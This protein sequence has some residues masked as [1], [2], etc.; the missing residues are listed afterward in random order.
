MS[1]SDDAVAR[2][3]VSVADGDLIDW[4]RADADLAQNERR[5]LR[6][7]RLV[8]SIASLHRSAPAEDPPGLDTPAL[9]PAGPRWGPLVVLERVGEGASS[10]VYRAWDSGLHRDVALKLIREDGLGASDAD[11]RTLDEG[12]RLARLRH[13]NVVHVY[14]AEKHDGRIGLW[15]ELVVGESLEEIVKARGPFGAREAAGIG[16]DLCAALAAVHEKHLL[17]RDIKA[18]NVV[19]EDGGRI[20]LMDFGTGE[21]LR[22]NLGT[23]RLVGTPLYLAP[24]IFR[25]EAA[26][27]QSDL[28]SLGVLLF[29]LVTGEFPVVAGN[30][31]QLAQAHLDRRG[32]RLRDLRPDLPESFVHAVERALEGDRERRFRTAGEMEA[33]L[34]ESL[35]P[36]E[37]P[38]P[39]PA[40]ARSRQARHVPFAAIAAA[41][42]LAIAALG[43]WARPRQ[44]IP[45][46]GAKRIAVLPLVDG[47]GSPASA[48]LASTLTEELIAGLGQ[49][50]ALQVS[51]LNSVL[52]FR[53]STQSGADISN[54]LGVEALVQGMVVSDDT[55]GDG[56]MRAQIR[57][58]AAGQP[59][60]LLERPFTRARGDI[61][62]LRTEIARA[63]ADAVNVRLT[64]DEATRFRRAHQ[65]TPAAEEAY[66]RGRI[67]LTAYGPEPARQA[68][69]AFQR[70]ISIDRN[71]AAAYAG[72]ARAYINLALH[73]G[74][75]N[76]DARGSATQAVRTALDLDDGLADGH[77]ILAEIYFRYDW[78][79]AGAEREYRTSLDLN[80]SYTYARAY[81]A[82]FLAAIRRFDEAYA[83]AT[84]AR[85]Q[86]PQSSDARILPAMVQY[87]RG[88]FDAAEREAHADSQ[89]LAR[90]RESQGR[91]E[92]ALAIT[93]QVTE[94][95]AD[96]SS[97][98]LRVSLIRRK[99]LSGR[100]E[101][102]A[103]D[104]RALERDAAHKVVRF[105]ARDQG[106][107]HLAFG[108]VDQALSA[109]EN[110]VDERDPALVWV[111]VDPRLDG[112]RSH[113][114]FRAILQRMKMP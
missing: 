28:Y 85:T 13:P 112:I 79:W 35:R 12:R 90:I 39:V 111:G 65:T 58:L 95:L 100:S 10:D 41:T 106:F 6:H 42:L 45:M 23:N 36:S 76:P 77:A 14:G 43:Y 101:A 70:A 56:T 33:A 48:A 108:N 26:S 105:T 27:V 16:Q 64:P 3:A 17:H 46:P 9:E 98:P 102:A 92:E 63:V 20:V 51:P 84:T 91:F 40:R 29:Y 94:R 22:R 60:V 32:R 93:E 80:P 86:D 67:Q 87:Y 88:D 78:D 4:N 53:G 1:R 57:V 15:M 66:I 34:R 49:I 89:L 47:S 8:E 7:L 97:V 61:E 62:R 37:T 55:G 113:P 103:A 74:M 104:L 96:S 71:Y 44:P 59:G 24:E 75:S 25:G 114:R 30:M 110:A 18:Q 72:L 73:G 107:V 2:L 81:Y 109:F 83:E 50:S 54:R 99:A 21:E 38:S 52:P 69:A 5:L 31:P 82:Q 11:V 19:R 68:A